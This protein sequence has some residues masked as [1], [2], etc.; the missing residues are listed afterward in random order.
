MF[1]VILVSHVFVH[2]SFVSAVSFSLSVVS[3]CFYYTTVD[4]DVIKLRGFSVNYFLWQ[5]VLLTMQKYCS[6]VIT[7]SRRLC[8]AFG[9]CWTCSKQTDDVCCYEGFTL[10]ET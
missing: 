8:F 6:V 10:S 3:S 1:K 9:F 4:C 7:R 5:T 2:V